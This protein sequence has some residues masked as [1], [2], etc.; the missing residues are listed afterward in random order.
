MVISFEFPIILFCFQ[1]SGLTRNLPNNVQILTLEPWIASSFLLRLE[2]VLE[3]DEDPSLSQPAIV[4][5][6]GLFTPFEIT[7]IKETTLGANHFLG[8]TKRF[9]FRKGFALEDLILEKTH[10]M[11]DWLEWKIYQN[12]LHRSRFVADEISEDQLKI[13]LNPMQIRT[14]I[15]E[16]KKSGGMFN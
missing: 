5:L 6:Q 1:Y 11:Q 3:K 16:T 8:E 4:D 2:H 15:I 7:T 10:K 9:D 12:D 14:F 13:T